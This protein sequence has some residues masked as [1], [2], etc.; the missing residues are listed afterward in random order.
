MKKT[1][2]LPVKMSP[3]LK[4]DLVAVAKAAHRTAGAQ[5]RLYIEEGLA[6]DQA[7]RPKK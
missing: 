4:K 5:A 7:K 1:A 6:R 2:Y 3:D